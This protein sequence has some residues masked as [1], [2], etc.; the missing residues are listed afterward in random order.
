MP[1]NLETI[2]SFSLTVKVCVSLD[3]AVKQL[4]NK[5]ITIAASSELTK[6]VFC[7]SPAWFYEEFFQ[8]VLELKTCQYRDWPS[9]KKQKHTYLANITP[10]QLTEELQNYFKE[11]S[12]VGKHRHNGF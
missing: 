2:V 1:A 10:P 8:T 6:M 12:C 5:N 7:E 11:V 3:E 9:L 4:R